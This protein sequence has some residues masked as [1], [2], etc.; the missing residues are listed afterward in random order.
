MLQDLTMD[1]ELLKEIKSLAS[2]ALQGRL[3]LEKLGSDYFRAQLDGRMTRART[4]TYNAR[5]AD[6]MENTVTPC[7]KKLREI[8][9]DGVNR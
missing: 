2:E 7:E 5:A 1:I 9:R 8:L 3:K 4:T 6:V